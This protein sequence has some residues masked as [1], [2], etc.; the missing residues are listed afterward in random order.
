MSMPENETTVNLKS[1]SF[2]VIMLLHEGLTHI[3]SHKKPRLHF[4]EGFAL[5]IYFIVF[6]TYLLYLLSSYIFFNCL[7]FAL[8]SSCFSITFVLSYFWRSLFQ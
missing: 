4:G 6:S 1:A 7:I 2:V 3:H 8:V 5:M